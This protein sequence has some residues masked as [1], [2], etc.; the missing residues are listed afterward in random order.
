MTLKLLGSAVAL[1]IVGFVAYAANQPLLIAPM[2]ATAV[3][4]FS[5]P[6]SPVASAPNVFSAYAIAV[7]CSLLVA[8]YPVWW[9]AAIVV[10]LVITLTSAF[11]VIHPPAGAIPIVAVSA[12]YGTLALATAIGSTILVLV[13]RLHHKV[14]SK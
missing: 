6:H 8:M 12:H 5:L 4:L 3:L 11:K 1:G 7:L 14:D 13:A 9:L 2:G 10:G